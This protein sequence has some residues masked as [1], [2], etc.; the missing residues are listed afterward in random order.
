[1][2]VTHPQHNYFYCNP[3]KDNIL[4]WNAWLDIQNFAYNPYGPEWLCDGIL[5]EQLWQMP[6]YWLWMETVAPHGECLLLSLYSRH[7]S[8]DDIISAGDLDHDNNFLGSMRYHI[9][10]AGELKCERWDEHYINCPLAP[11]FLLMK[12]KHTSD[13][14]LLLSSLQ[15]PQV[16][17][18]FDSKVLIIT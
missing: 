14:T 15:W 11:R 6:C 3:K 10:E 4:Q 16:I 5:D 13:S 17:F 2:A 9:F 1:M 18:R 8:D 7:I 12:S